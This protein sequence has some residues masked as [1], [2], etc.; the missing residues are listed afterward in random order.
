[1]IVFVAFMALQRCEDG[2]DDR[3]ERS[4]GHTLQKRLFADHRILVEHRRHHR[5][6]R[7]AGCQFTGGFH[8]PAFDER[9]LGRQIPAPDRANRGLDGLARPAVF[10]MRPAGFSWPI[11]W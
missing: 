4:R 9:N 5:F 6:E 11:R 1:M 10:P 7:D 3:I 8:H 2:S